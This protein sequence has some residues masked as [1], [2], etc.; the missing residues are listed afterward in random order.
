MKPAQP[1]KPEHQGTREVVREKLKLFRIPT[2]MGPK[3]ADTCDGR[4][5]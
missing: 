5:P 1:Y 2:L 3:R 4:R